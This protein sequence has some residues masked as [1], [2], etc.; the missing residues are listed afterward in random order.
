MSKRRS[1]GEGSAYQ[2]AMAHGEALSTSVRT[3]AGVVGSTFGAGRRQKFSAR[4]VGLSQRRKKVGCA[5][6]ARRLWRHG[7][8][9]ISQKSP[10]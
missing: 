6:I 8:T 2:I 9:A 4:F 10:R 5:R 1:P 3:K 7:L